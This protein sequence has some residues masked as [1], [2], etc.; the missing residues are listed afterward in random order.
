VPVAS[1]VSARVGGPPSDGWLPAGRMTRASRSE[2]PAGA[3]LTRRAACASVCGPEPLSV[4]P[5]ECGRGPTS[6]ESPLERRPRKRGPTSGNPRWW[7]YRIKSPRAPLEGYT[8][9]G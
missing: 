4:W 8:P 3:M 5:R 7:W 6:G 2:Q 1:R 9:D